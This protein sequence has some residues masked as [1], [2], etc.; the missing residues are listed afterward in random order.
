M[1]FNKKFVKKEDLID[2]FKLEGYQGIINY[3]GSSDA[4]FG[5][6]DDIQNILDLTYCGMCPTKKNMEINKL[7]YGSK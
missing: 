7:I 5:L 6:D 2:R 3:I 1:G 4:L